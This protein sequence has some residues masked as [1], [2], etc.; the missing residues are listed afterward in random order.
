MAGKIQI[1][2]ITLGEADNKIHIHTN[3][4]PNKHK[5]KYK[6]NTNTNQTQIQITNTVWFRTMQ[7]IT[8]QSK[9]KYKSNKNTNT[10]QFCS[11]QCRGLQTN[12]SQ[13]LQHGRKLT[14]VLK[15]KK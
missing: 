12:P 5:Y 14:Q 8:S 11:G 9:Y 10:N 4:N 13:E 6:S 2:Q 1:M 3:T 7:R 15:G